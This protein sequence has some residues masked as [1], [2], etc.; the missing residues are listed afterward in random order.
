MSIPAGR[1]SS[2]RDPTWRAVGVY[3][4]AAAIALAAVPGGCALPAPRRHLGAEE[5]WRM[6]YPRGIP[7][8]VAERDL[9]EFVHPI[10]WQMAL[11][12]SFRPS[13]SVRS[14]DW[15][16]WLRCGLVL[17][18]DGP[19]RSFYWGGA[20]EL[21]VR[22][23]TI[24]E[25]PYMLWRIR[26]VQDASLGP[27]WDIH[28]TNSGPRLHVGDVFLA[29][30]YGPLAARILG[31]GYL[32]QCAGSLNQ[33]YGTDSQ[34]L[35]RVSDPTEYSWGDGRAATSW[36][37]LMSVM[38]WTAIARQV[39]F[40]SELYAFEKRGLRP[41]SAQDLTSVIGDE[42]AQHW[43]GPVRAFVAFLIKQS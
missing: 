18:S 19:H 22:L 24:Y 30:Q 34:P 10:V 28:R 23:E 36:D 12:G 27:A 29:E 3:A 6:L 15:G 43:K 13:H 26:G 7:A 21:P 25:S 40:G 17:L 41:G 11:E 16:A 5:T 2:K 35:N 8:D 42:I 14:G 1:G 38:Y 32:L 20:T 9:P 33:E 37:D 4:L 31:Q 39:T